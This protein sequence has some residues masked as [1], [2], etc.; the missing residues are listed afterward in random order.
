LRV[1]C[2]YSALD[3]DG[4]R[5]LAKGAL[6]GHQDRAFVVAD[7]TP[8]VRRRSRT[9][10]LGT[11][12]CA[13]VLGGMLFFA[14]VFAPLVFRNPSPAAAGSFIRQVAMSITPC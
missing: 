11:L 8:S 13:I 10:V 2:S 4:D 12:P 3:G 6:L 7:R 1:P 14:P 5:T 9:Q